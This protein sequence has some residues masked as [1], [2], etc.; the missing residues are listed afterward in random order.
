MAGK[1][2]NAKHKI[3]RRLGCNLWGRAKSPYNLRQTG[4]GQHGAN[5][6]KPTDYGIQLRAKQKLKGYYGSIGEK[7]FRAYYFEAIR[8]RGDSSQNLIGL[9]ERRLDAVCYRAKFVP[10]VFASRQLVSHG[11][12]KV[13]GK[14]VN[15]PS[16]QVKEGDVV[17]VR[18][19]SRQ[20]P[21]V[22]AAR[23][24]GERDI[25]EYLAEDAAGFKITFVRVPK[26]ED[27]PYPVQMEPN[28]VIEYYSR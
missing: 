21:M 12:V 13:N 28:L 15:V 2:L 19:K 11:H 22:M 23:E 25:P 5:R 27:V 16:Y 10:T 4:P 14:R 8:L 6:G 3:D 20:M 24:S 26:L 17:E 18:E 7:K 9:L 1:R